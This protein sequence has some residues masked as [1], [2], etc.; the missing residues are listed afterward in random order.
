MERYYSF[1]AWCRK[2]YGRKLY[3][4]ALDAGMTCPNRDGKLGYGGCIFCAGGSGDFAVKYDGSSFTEEQLVYNHQDAQPGD[5]IAYFQAY[6]NTYALIEKLRLL[7]ESAME[8]PLFAGISVATRPDCFSEETY[9]LFRELKEKYPGKMLMAELGLQ[10]IHQSSAGWMHRGY[11]LPVFE[12]CVRRLRSDQ[13]DVTVHVIIGL[14]D[15]TPAMLYETIRYLNGCDIQ[16]IKLQL[17]HYLKSS[18]LGALYQKNPEKYHV[19]TLE[20]Y[21]DLVA[22]C[23]ARLD[24]NIAVHRLTGDG[25]GDELLAPMWSRDKRRVLNTIRHVMKEKNITQGCRKE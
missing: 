6:T 25:A 15:E 19:L 2:T 5:Y 7:F 22:E 10:T 9:Q 17:L 3:K 4:A 24:E 1:P 13:I 16:G 20:E 18:E 11:E 23:I 14:P 8:N 21:A 12:E